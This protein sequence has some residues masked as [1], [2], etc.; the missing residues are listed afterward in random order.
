MMADTEKFSPGFSWTSISNYFE[1]LGNWT[2]YDTHWWSD[3]R[4]I[5]GLFSKSLD[6]CQNILSKKL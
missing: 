3:E 5:L 2:L 1:V 4:I 6:D